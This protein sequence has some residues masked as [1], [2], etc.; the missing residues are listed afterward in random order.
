METKKMYF[1]LEYQID[2]VDKWRPAMQLAANPAEA[3]EQFTV[4]YS[5]CFGTVTAVRVTK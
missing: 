1:D 2:F 4:N 5:P 3:I